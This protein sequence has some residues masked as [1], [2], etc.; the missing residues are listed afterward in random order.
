MIATQPMLSRIRTWLRGA[1]EPSD[2]PVVAQDDAKREDLNTRLQTVARAQSK[3]SLR[4][5]AIAEQMASNHSELLAR[6]GEPPPR[7]TNHAS[8]E[9]VLEAIDRLDDAA[10]SIG[11]DQRAL[12]EGLEAIAD[13]L[14]RVLAASGIVRHASIGGAP[15]GRHVRVIGTERRDDLPDGV[16]TRVVRSAATWQTEL[17]RE[18]EVLV[19]KLER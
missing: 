6:L 8:H 12:A 9:G 14:A 18:G 7:P 3:L 19:N 15:D 5:D 13:R 2:P 17:L 4:L 10:R 1:P 16:V 11:A